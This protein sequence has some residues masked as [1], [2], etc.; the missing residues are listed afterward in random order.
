[1]QARRL[2]QSVE[3]TKEAAKA[4][5]DS[6][7]ALPA[8]ERAYIFVDMDGEVSRPTCKNIPGK[9]NFY[10]TAPI[11]LINVGKTPAILKKIYVGIIK[12][13]TIDK[14]TKTQAEEIIK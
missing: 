8:I 14:L 9:G 10:F 7:G 12:T 11:N 2:R 4:A 6:A 5:K 3:A 1:M 13:K